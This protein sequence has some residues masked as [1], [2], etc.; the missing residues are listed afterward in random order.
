MSLPR[1][2]FLESLVRLNRLDA[3]GFATWDFL[4]GM[5]FG[6]RAAWWSG[7]A[8]RATPHEGLDICLYRTGEGRRLPLGAG[9]R[10]P[11]LWPGEVVALTLDFLGV[12][13]FVAHAWQDREGRRLHSVYGHLDPRPGLAWGIL[14]AAGEEVGAVA[15][16]S[17]SRGAAPPH[18]HLTVA[19][20][21]GGSGPGRLDWNTM[22][23][24]SRVRL[25]DPLPILC[26]TMPP[27]GGGRLTAT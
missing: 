7:G 9:A 8:Q 27:H 3:A 25:L 24:S 13:V 18:L 11:A 4:P 22:R 12:S 5:R 2:T 21:G 1:S 16:P 20:V 17:G 10:V 26:D 23:E 19:L 15:Q 6:E 14:L